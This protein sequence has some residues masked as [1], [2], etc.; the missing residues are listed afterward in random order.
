MRSR[1]AIYS[2]IVIGA[3]R[4]GNSLRGTPHPRSISART[5]AVPATIQ[6]AL[7]FMRSMPSPE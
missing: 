1:G 7:L 2:V 6:S 3:R 4:D 5:S